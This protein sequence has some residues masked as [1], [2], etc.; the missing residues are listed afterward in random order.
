MAER[1]PE[2]QICCEALPGRRP[3]RKGSMRRAIRWRP[4]CWQNALLVLLGSALIF[5]PT[6]TG[7]DVYP[8]AAL[9]SR[10][11]AMLLVI[12]SLWTLSGDENVLPETFNAVLGL[13]FVVAAFG[14]HCVP[15]H[16]ATSV[17]AGA[18][19]IALSLWAVL[20]S[21][22]EKSDATSSYTARFAPFSDR[23]LDVSSHAPPERQTAENVA[24]WKL[25]S[26]N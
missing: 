7:E 11:L 12:V 8:H 3:A 23:L 26:W 2:Q 17:A 19:V 6:F 21:L 5:A 18:V 1:A 22:G 25:A 20:L 24:T 9:V 16:Q 13:G 10:T 14:T 4:R 15:A